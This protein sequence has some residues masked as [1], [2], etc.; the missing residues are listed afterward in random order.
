MSQDP[1]PTGFESP[2]VLPEAPLLFSTPTWYVRILCFQ[3][4]PSSILPNTR[5][6][7]LASDHS[8]RPHLCTDPNRPDWSLARRVV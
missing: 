5:G 2:A 8:A 4:T 1:K 3:D 6:V 7:P